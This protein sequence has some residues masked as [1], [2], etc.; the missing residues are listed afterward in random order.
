MRTIKFR[1]WDGKEMHEGA[2]D[3]WE[4]LGD[5]VELMQFTGLLDKNR[6]EIYEGDILKNDVGLLIKG[7]IWDYES[8]ASIEQQI[9]EFDEEIKWYVIGNIY[10]NPELL[11]K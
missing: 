9:K 11:I 2:F 3:L 1:A 6:K 7:V 4:G 10:K 5:G 8:L